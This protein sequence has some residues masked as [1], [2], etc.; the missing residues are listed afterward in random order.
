M[1]TLPQLIE[2]DVREIDAALREFVT[3]TSSLVAVLVD[4][5]GFVL[6][7]QGDAG[8]VDLTTLGALAS[9]AFMASQT[10]AGLVNEKNFSSTFQQGEKHSLLCTEVDHHSLL[11]VLFKSQSGAG[12]VKYYSGNCTSRIARQMITAQER[13]PQGGFDLSALNMA[14]PQE[15]FRK[16]A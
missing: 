3:Q 2:D 15:L 8:E 13:T 7:S 12:L 1:A 9:G 14:H 16:K 4:K 10:I 6:S 11:L 5:G